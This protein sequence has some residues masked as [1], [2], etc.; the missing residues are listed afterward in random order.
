[1]KYSPQI[2]GR[3]CRKKSHNWSEWEPLVYKGGEYKKHQCLRC[4]RRED[5]IPISALITCEFKRK[6]MTSVAALN[7]PNPIFEAMKRHGA[8]RRIDGGRTIVEEL[9]EKGIR[10]GLSAAFKGD[11]S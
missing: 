3:W 11:K 9:G 7:A 2:A 6:Y 4:G 8:I 10:D 5:T 1:M